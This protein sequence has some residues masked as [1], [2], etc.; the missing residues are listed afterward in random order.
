MGEYPDN[1]DYTKVSNSYFLIK[2]LFQS[3]NVTIFYIIAIFNFQSQ[4]PGPLNDEIELEELERKKQQKKLKREKEK[5]KKKEQELK[6]KEEAARQSFLNL[7]DREKVNNKHFLLQF[8]IQFVKEHF[9]I[10]V[11]KFQRAA[12]AEKRMQQGAKMIR[13]FNCGTE[14]M[15]KSTFEYDG[16]K[17]CCMTC[18]KG[19]RANNKPANSS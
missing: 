1:F 8:E 12:A 4:I 7:S 14:V 5:V 19:H 6:K 13:C 17:F 2:I 11:M 3:K 15:E 16:N 18:L 9:L 10:K